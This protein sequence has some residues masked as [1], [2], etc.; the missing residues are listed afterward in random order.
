MQRPLSFLCVSWIA[1]CAAGCGTTE[2]RPVPQPVE[3][4]SKPAPAAD[5]AKRPWPTE[6]AAE[7]LLIGDVIEIEGPEGLIEHLAVRQEGQDVEYKAETTAD[8]FL[9]TWNAKG[10]AEVRG[11]LDNCVLAA[12]QR[13]SALE[14]PGA[15]SVEIRATGAV[16]KRR[17]PQGWTEARGTQWKVSYSLPRP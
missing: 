17:G 9:Q 3:A 13:L 14:R 4:R 16:F 5:S 2:P 6:L 8:G 12:L 1:L 7:A 15:T 10:G 11:Q